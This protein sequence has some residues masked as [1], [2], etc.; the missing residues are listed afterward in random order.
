MGF[1]PGQDLV[2]EAEEYERALYRR[3]MKALKEGAKKKKKADTS[4]IKAGVR[5]GET[6]DDDEQD[7]QSDEDA[8]L[9][10]E[11]AQGF[12]E[13]EHRPEGPPRA[14]D[15]RGRPSTSREQCAGASRTPQRRLLAAVAVAVVVVAVA[16]VVVMVVVMVVVVVVMAASRRGRTRHDWTLKLCFRHSSPWGSTVPR[17]IPVGTR[18]PPSPSP[19]PMT[20][21]S[22]LLA[23]TTGPRGH[24]GHSRRHKPQR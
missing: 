17:C 9:A 19:P 22:L 7:E 14:L 18:A 2:R 6:E 23:A 11:A 10:A 1:R 13:D 24:G 12:G 4:A 21:R 3:R 15:D 20:P 16:V 8:L 5:A